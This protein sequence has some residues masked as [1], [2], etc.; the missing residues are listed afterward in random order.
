M[1]YPP[2]WSPRHSAPVQRATGP[3]SC[4]GFA[5]RGFFLPAS[6][7]PWSQGAGQSSRLRNTICGGFT[8]CFAHGPI[9][10][11]TGTYLPCPELVLWQLVDFLRLARSGCATT[12]TNRQ[13]L[14][15]TTHIIPL[16]S[17]SLVALG[18][19][20]LRLSMHEGPPIPGFPLNDLT[21]RRRR[22]CFILVLGPAYDFIIDILL[23]SSLP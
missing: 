20:L 16:I 3:R 8:S 9:A 19:R 17:P 2:G 10:C 7:W 4:H 22:S 13:L 1:R 12:N 18:P 6:I 21:R 23:P 15:A 5:I 14:C 11:L